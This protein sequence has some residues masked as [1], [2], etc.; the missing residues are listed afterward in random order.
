MENKLKKDTL[1]R[2]TRVYW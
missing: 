1:G 2:A